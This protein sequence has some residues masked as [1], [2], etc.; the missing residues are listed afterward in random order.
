MAGT[1]GTSSPAC[2]RRS[3]GIRRLP[4]PPPGCRWAKSSWRNPFRA[5]RVMARASPRARAAVVLAVGTRFRGHASAR[6]PQS[7]ATSALRARVDPGAP[8]RQTS[9]A[10][11]RRMVS[12]RRRISFVSPLCD[13][14]TTTSSSCTTPRSPWTA[15]AGC[16]KNAGVPVLARV[17]AILRLMIP[18]LPMPV[19][20]T[21]PAQA[22]S[23]RTAASKPVVEPVRERPQRLRL[24]L[25]D[26]PRQRP[27]DRRGAGGGHAPWSLVASATRSTRSSNCGSRSSRSAFCASLFA[28]EGSS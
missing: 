9:R 4:S 8:V 7:R 18:D 19:T 14:A 21:R 25:D 23:R 13:R 3:A 22:S 28:R 11:T 10:P 6:T 12:I 2:M 1:T 20:M 5:S 24:D 17:A 16:R 26:L 15:S 27:V